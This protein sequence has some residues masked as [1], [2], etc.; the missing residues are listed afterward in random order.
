MPFAVDRALLGMLD[1]AGKKAGKMSD[2]ATLAK[3]AAKPVTQTR[4]KH[5]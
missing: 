1:F 4:A 3:V 5:L 2:R